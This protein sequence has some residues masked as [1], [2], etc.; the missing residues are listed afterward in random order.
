M[1]WK[2]GGNPILSYWHRL[3]HNQ[4]KHEEIM[5]KELCKLGV[6]Y[7]TQ[8][9]FRIGNK[10]FFADFYLPDNKLV[11]EIDDP[12]HEKEQKKADD[13]ERTNALK[14]IGLEVI[15]FS[16]HQVEQNV[17]NCVIM[18]KAWINRT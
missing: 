17:V 4:T 12:G 18:V 10:N 15:R 13:L 2:R 9:P 3:Y 1:A 14:T 8:H 7:R 5:E 11:I 6:R 16:N